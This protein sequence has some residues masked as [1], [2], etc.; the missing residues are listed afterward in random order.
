MRI[1]SLISFFF[2]LVV[3]ANAQ[4]KGIAKSAVFYSP[5]QGY[6]VET[7]VSVNAKSLV[8]NK[9]KDGYRGAVQVALIVNTDTSSKIVASYYLNSIIIADTSQRNFEII[10]MHRFLIGAG[11]FSIR[12]ELKD[13]S[14]NTSSFEQ[15]IPITIKEN[16]N[17]SFLSDVLL[18]R[19]ID[20]CTSGIFCKHGKY[21]PPLFSNFI[22]SD[23]NKLTFFVEGYQLDSAISKGASFL[24]Q[25]RILK[26]DETKKPVVLVASKK[27][28]AQAVNIWLQPIDVSTLRSGTY[29]LEV[30][31]F[32][33]L[34]VEQAKK[35]TLFRRYKQVELDTSI[36]S[37]N[38][39][40]FKLFSVTDSLKEYIR[41]TWPISTSS[42]K[43]NA[44]ALLKQNEIELFQNYLFNFWRARLL[45]NPFDA[46]INYQSKVITV[47]K[48]FGTRLKKG[49]ETDRGR[50]YLKYGAPNSIVDK[51]NDGVNN[52]YQIWHY[53][54][55]GNQR[56]RKFV[57]MDSD[58]ILND[59]TLIH[60][61]AQGETINKDWEDQLR[62][63]NP[64]I[65]TIEDEL[66][67]PH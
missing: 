12:L 26:V 53:Y 62:Q 49:Y 15:V 5:E 18:I 67:T 22:E 11:N 3:I 57:F 36:V 56:D 29:E 40:P 66:K 47:N 58:F 1:I 30:S 14:L 21:M 8:F 19:M 6:Y 45:Y 16:V 33:S 42:E 25:Y 48:A 13:S 61:N 46:F 35:S 27:D 20:S 59:Y 54:S 9:Y 43:I 7:Y 39:N 50:V 32:D 37:V 28:K 17:R 23:I 51:V 31:I 65:N 10:D 55:L 38:D 44:T 52:P 24:W 4:I 41:S 63:V 2:I 34:Q 64:T 60:S